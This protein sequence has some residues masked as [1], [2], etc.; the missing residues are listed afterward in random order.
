MPP[1]PQN[2][3]LC[4]AVS[5]NRQHVSPL[6]S[7]H[8]LLATHTHFLI[9]T[10]DMFLTTHTCTAPG[11]QRQELSSSVPSHTAA[12][13]EK[14]GSNE[15][16]RPSQGTCEARGSSRGLR[17]LFLSRAHSFSPWQWSPKP[18]ALTLSSLWQ[19]MGFFTWT[20]MTSD[21]SPFHSGVW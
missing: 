2:A 6:L 7:E 8:Y 12:P 3:R 10:A 13:Y 4:L 20:E 17:S 21:L 18:P 16:D 5:R 14:S 11:R 1:S 15:R 9:L 19:Q